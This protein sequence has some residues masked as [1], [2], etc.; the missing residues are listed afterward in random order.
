ME[1]LQVAFCARLMPEAVVGGQER[2]SADVLA[3][4][5]H[6]FAVLDLANH[7]P[8]WRQWDYLATLGARL[9]MAHRK[10]VAEVVDASDG[11]LAGPAARCGL[12]SV[13]RA[14][15]KDVSWDHPAYQAYARR[16]FP[17]I[18]R[19]VAN[20]QATRDRVLGFGVDADRVEVVNPMAEAPPDWR[21]HPIPGR[22][23]YAGRLVAKK[24]ALE[25]VRD[26]WPRVADEHPEAR[27][28]IVGDGPMRAAVE[29]AA[30][31][32]PHADRIQVLG[33][34]PRER[35]EE[36]FRQADVFAMVSR[37]TPGDF[38]GF[39]IVNIEAAVRGV[40]VVAYDADGVRDAVEHGR[41]GL[42]LPDLD[43]QAAA[44]AFGEVLQGR[45]KDRRALASY[46]TERWGPA[47]FRTQYNGVVRRTAL[48][49]ARRP[50]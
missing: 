38:E 6:D 5:R 47:R 31:T 10:G 30:R 48:D 21:P 32:A 34:V 49:G 40:P 35:L 45:F 12:P 7:G 46:A 25:L 27:L 2:L 1:R 37:S 41:T 17:R 50:L 16:H 4:L 23:L 33:R 29:E 36:E 44:A 22:I 24:G 14:N 8:K 39:G 11:S 9:R 28:H 43:P 42:V 13:M 15:G 19:I 3:T 18:T 26:V 20:S